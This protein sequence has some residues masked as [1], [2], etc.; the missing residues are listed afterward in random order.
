[1]TTFTFDR[2]WTRLCGLDRASLLLLV[3]AVVFAI[4]LVVLIRTRWGHSRSL[5]KCVLFSVLAHVLLTAYAATVKFVTY[6]PAPKEQF[7]RIALVDGPAG[8]EHGQLGGDRSRS[9]PA[10]AQSRQIRRRFPTPRT[11]RESKSM[12]QRGFQPA[13]HKRSRKPCRHAA[14]ARPRSGNWRVKSPHPDGNWQRPRN[15]T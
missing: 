13:P 4:A 14:G 2:L 7:V 11:A 9:Q 10:T 1:M 15:D 6:R 8:A 3:G 12:V 5:E